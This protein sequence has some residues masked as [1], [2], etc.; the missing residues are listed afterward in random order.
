MD[1]LKIKG[2]GHSITARGGAHINDVDFEN[3]GF[4]NEKGSSAVVEG[5]LTTDS[6]ILNKG[7]FYIKKP[8][9]VSILMGNIGNWT[10]RHPWVFNT[11]IGLIVAFILWLAHLAWVNL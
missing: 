3:L 8:G 5:K 2:N 10:A 6:T 7:D 1:N 4:I 9:E 11:V